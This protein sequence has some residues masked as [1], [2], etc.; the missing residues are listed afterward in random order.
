[1]FTLQQNEDFVDHDHPCLISFQQ[2]D[3]TPD[4]YEHV[5]IVDGKGKSSIRYPESSTRKRG[6][7]RQRNKP[8]LGDGG[9]GD[10]GPGGD[11]DNDQMQKKM[12]HREIERQRRQEMTKLYASLRDLLPLEL[13]KGTRSIS[14]HMNQAVHYIK[15]ME[16]NVKELSSK[17][18]QLKKFSNTNENSTNNLPNTVSVS[19]CNEGVQI[20]I[21]SCLI[22]EGF[23]LSGV[24]NTLVEQGLNVTSC[25]LTKVKDRL[26]HSIQT[27]A[28]DLALIDLSMLQQRLSLVANARTNF[29]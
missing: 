26:I 25:S 2:E 13:I 6:G 16:E 17:R 8:G 18:D 10:G 15:Q 21:N 22:E 5:P 19:L 24:F 11:G 7:D 4:L 28:S 20:S 27:E 9:G 12:F 3:H 29:D 23:M 1:M 14:D